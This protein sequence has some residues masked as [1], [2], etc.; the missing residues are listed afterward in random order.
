MK[1]QFIKDTSKPTLNS[2]RDNTLFVYRDEYHIPQIEGVKS[3]EFEKYKLTYMD[4]HPDMIVFFGL[5]QI[6]V[7]SNRCEF[8]FEYL[9]ANTPQIEKISVDSSPFIGEPWRLWF[10]F[11]LVHGSWL[12]TTYSYFVET[13][14]QHWF[15]RDSESSIISAPNIH[16]RLDSVYSDLDQLTTSFVLVEPD[17]HQ[18][19]LYN[20][21]KSFA[22][23]KYATPKLIIQ[24]M[25]KELNKSIGTKISFESY[26]TND[27]ITVP[28]FGI[29]RFVV[30]ENVRR[31]KIYNKIIHHGIKK[32][33]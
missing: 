33:I 9:Y 31:M 6:I 11:A 14:W 28:S 8:V 15:Y 17:E 27:T 19:S 25:L 16:E 23:E 21:L 20:E 2:I 22:F 10:H 24:F 12:G 4:Y 13:D 5:N 26:L 3:I 29:Y 32:N 18:T 1:I 30:E 7:P